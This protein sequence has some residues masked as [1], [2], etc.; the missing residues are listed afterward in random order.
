MSP[1][2][3]M[4]ATLD[5]ALAAA[6]SASGAPGG[7]A[8]SRRAA[9]MAAARGLNDLLIRHALV[10]DDV[11]A[12]GSRLAKLC[13]R[14]GSDYEAEREAAYDHALRLLLR[15][16]ATWSD[17]VRLPETLMREAAGRPSARLSPGRSLAREGAGVARRTPPGAAVRAA[18]AS[19]RPAQ[20]PA[21]ASPPEEDWMATVRRLKVG[22]TWRSDAEHALLATLE[23][24]LAEGHA[25][26]AEDARRLRDIWWRVEL[27]EPAPKEA[28]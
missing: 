7:A 13:G 28:T 5:D 20:R 24:S 18:G 22:A 11:V 1:A 26:S 25:I 2:A 16:R 27:N 23:R 19:S 4:L 6:A 12:P 15:R 3:A 10:W 14:L 9:G 8:G 21:V 17:L